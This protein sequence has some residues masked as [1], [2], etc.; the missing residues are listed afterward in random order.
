MV[1]LFG[2][3][4]LLAAALPSAALEGEKVGVRFFGESR[5]PFCRRFTTTSLADLISRPD[6]LSY[7]DLDYI[8]WGNGYF[9]SQEC[10]GGPYDASER[11][12]WAKVRDVV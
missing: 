6:V 3:L 5:C 1:A 8:P 12:C 11:Q 10:G 9:S 7:V 4:S 2:L